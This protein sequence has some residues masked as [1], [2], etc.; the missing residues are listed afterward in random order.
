METTNMPTEV[1]AGTPMPHESAPVLPTV[2]DVIGGVSTAQD[3]DMAATPDESSRPEPG[4]L[5]GKRAKWRAEWENEHTQEVTKLRGELDTLREYVINDQADKLVA[6][7]KVTDRELALELSRSRNGY[8]AKPE[9]TNTPTAERPRD[10]QGRFVSQNPNNNPEIP[11]S[12]Q[13]RANELFEQARTL[14]KFSGVDVLSVYRSNPE[15]VEKINSGEWDMTD[16]LTAYNQSGQRSIPTPVR[17]AHTG[18]IK[19]V[20][21]RNMSSEQ[22]EKLNRALESGGKYSIK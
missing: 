20:D 11:N 14:Q 3:Q 17:N 8:G 19:P 9:V 7:G 1:L 2:S 16:V 22:F 12:I 5:A 13:I 6:S 15:Y 4:Y 10:A 18:G 21:F